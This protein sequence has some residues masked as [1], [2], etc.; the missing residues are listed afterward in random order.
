MNTSGRQVKFQISAGGV[1]AKNTQAVG[2][3]PFR[4]TPPSLLR[5]NLQWR[6]SVLNHLETIIF[7]VNATLSLQSQRHVKLIGLISTIR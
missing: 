1:H 4:T 5:L 7:V 6:L 3:E 2:L